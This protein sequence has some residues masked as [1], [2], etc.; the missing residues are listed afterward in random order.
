MVKQQQQNNNNNSNEIR[1]DTERTNMFCF[2]TFVILLT[3]K[4]AE[5]FSPL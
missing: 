3:N 5:G 1:E 2:V 4:V